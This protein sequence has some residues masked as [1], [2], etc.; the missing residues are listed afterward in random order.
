MYTYIYIYI[1]IHIHNV[2]LCVCMYVCV[3]IYIYI[4]RQGGTRV[5]FAVAFS[6]TALRVVTG[7]VGSA[8]P[9]ATI[10]NRRPGTANLRT[11]ILETGECEINTHLDV[12]GVFNVPTPLPQLQS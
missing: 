8:R 1:H 4:Y 11:R 5:T 3:Y 6:G 7:F 10:K 12:A 2:M 9:W